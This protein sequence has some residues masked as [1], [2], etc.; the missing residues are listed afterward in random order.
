IGISNLSVSNF[1]LVSMAALMAG[2]LQAPLTAIF[3]IAEITGGY[4]L[5]IPLMIVSSIS[6]LTVKYFVQHSVYHMQL[7]K[8]G[9]LITHHKDQAVLTLMQLTNEIERDFEKVQPYQ[10]LG[11]L[12][13]AVAKSNRN[14]F[15]VV[16][17][18]NRFIGVVLLN[19]IRTI[20]F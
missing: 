20:M 3:L 17:Q 11:D 8:K 9:A 19:D 16:D 18:E 12:V 2:I 4:E 6:F 15:P 10:T 7:A 14:L 13:K 1:T 5:F